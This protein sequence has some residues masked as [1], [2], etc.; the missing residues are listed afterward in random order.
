MAIADHEGR[1]GP[2]TETPGKHRPKKII[3]LIKK[4]IPVSVY[5][6]LSFESESESESES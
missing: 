5:T 1:F 2:W 4:N 6:Y 3:N